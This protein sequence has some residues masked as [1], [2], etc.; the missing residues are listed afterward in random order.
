MRPQTDAVGAS[1]RAVALTAAASRIERAIAAADAISTALAS[2]LGAA[3]RAVWQYSREVV[4]GLAEY[5]AAAGESAPERARR[6]AAAIARIADAVRH[7]R[8]IDERYKGTWGAHDFEWARE[9]WLTAL[10]R[11]L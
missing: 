6:G 4:Q 10:R 2:R 7:V 3:E 1:A 8:E 9:R 5:L 11:N